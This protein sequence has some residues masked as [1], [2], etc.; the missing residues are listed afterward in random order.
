MLEQLRNNS[1]SGI[2]YFLFG[3]IIIVFVFTFN[4][5]GPGGGCTGGEEWPA[6]SVNGDVVYL[7]DL[8]LGMRLSANP[9]ANPMDSFG[10]A[11]FQGTR[12]ARLGLSRP[13]LPSPYTPADTF[14]RGE[15]GTMPTKAGKVA[16]D[17][18]E[19]FLVSQEA[20]RVG[21]RVTDAELL[22]AVKNWITTEQGEFSA[23][24]YSN[25]I[26]YGLGTTRQKFEGLVTK[27]L[28]RRKLVQLVAAQG[29]VDPNEVNYYAG[30]LT[31]K[32]VVEYA[33]VDADAVKALIAVSAAEAAEYAKAN[34]EKITAEYEKRTAEF[35]QPEKVQL[36]GIFKKA[37]FP[38]QIENEKDPTKKA[39]LEGTRADAKASLEAIAADL[40]AAAA[41]AAAEK[42]AAEEAAKAAALAAENG[43]EVA[44]APAAPAAEAKDLFAE[45]AGEASDDASKTAGGKFSVPLSKEALGRYPYGESVAEAAFA[46][47]PGEISTVV[48]VNRGF[49]LLR[50]ESKVAAF[51]KAEADVAGE[52]ATDL[53]RSEKAPAEVENAAKAFLAAAKAASD[54]SLS[55]VAGSFE[56]GAV[57]VAETLPLAQLKQLGDSDGWKQV[58]GLG[59]APT[60]VKGAFN[61][62][63]EAP[64]ADETFTVFGGVN[65]NEDTGVRVIAK[66][67][68]KPETTE[69]EMNT[70]KEAV[71][72]Q[73]LAFNARETYRSWYAALE[74]SADVSMTSEF[75]EYLKREEAAMAGEGV[76]TGA[77]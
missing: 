38:A 1:K 49:W 71:E 24:I 11:M 39:E 50:M 64:L 28:L 44:E 13:D 7:S 54:K 70:A 59:C 42:K 6:A 51:S 17:L 73:L 46:L 66:W 32:V 65:C 30:L 74:K 8:E 37:P 76:A 52:L 10:S 3:I 22:A 31:D 36:S 27:E 18:V 45:K 56:G 60:L 34:P 41:A 21:L 35:N 40:N 5:S 55:D 75:G 77:P 67:A 68:S 9:P 57:T 53:I 26:R 23:E 47:A 14:T 43:E 12:Y 72:S 4:T 25:T 15:E 2:I 33:K 58:G 62:S 29:S 20:E 48:E 19:T 63:A 69:E 16:K 61:L